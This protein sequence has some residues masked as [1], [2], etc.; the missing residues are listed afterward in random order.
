MRIFA[1]CAAEFQHSVRKAAGVQPLLSPPATA[2]IFDPRW[3]EGRDF[4][5]LKLHGLPEET[6][7]YGDNWLTALR[8]TQILAANL[9][10][11]V[12]FVA[13]CH[14]YQALPAPACADTADRQAGN[15]DYHPTSPMLN[16]LLIAGARAVV[17]GSGD[18]HAKTHSIH[19]ADRLGRA[20]RY[21]LQFGL[22][23]HPAFRLAQAWLRFSFNHKSYQ[24]AKE[25][26]ADED[27]LNFRYF[28][29]GSQGPGVRD[30]GLRT[31]QNRFNGW[32]HTKPR[33]AR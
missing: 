7:W 32:P 8:A 12:I 4:I 11:T 19:G 10:G 27:T 17:G 28:A 21:L 2:H 22:A 24:S 23:P 16:A 3:L 25:R 9:T 13:N 20:L 30:Q 6:Y 5:Y 31:H 33:L 26:L 15:N 18:N 1:Y 29:G 14:L